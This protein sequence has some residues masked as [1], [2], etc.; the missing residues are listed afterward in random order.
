[1]TALDLSRVTWRKS[2]RCESGACIEVATS[3][4]NA[5]Y[6]RRDDAIFMIRDSTRS[7]GPI[8]RL[9]LNAWS[10]FIARIKEDEPEPH[11][12]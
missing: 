2:R 6:T 12:P 7:A 3:G 10:A 8:L 5:D 1:L 9:T 4:H 11:C